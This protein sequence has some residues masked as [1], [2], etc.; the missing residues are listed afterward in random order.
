MMQEMKLKMTQELTLKITQKMTVQ[1]TQENGL[2]YK[3][4]KNIFFNVII[5]EFDLTKLAKFPLTVFFQI[6]MFFFK[7]FS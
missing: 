5:L 6:F 4:D 3:S 2:V 7:F 1:M